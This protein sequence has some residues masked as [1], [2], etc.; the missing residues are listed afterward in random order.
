MFLKGLHPI[1]ADGWADRAFQASVG[2]IGA[3]CLETIKQEISDLPAKEPG[4]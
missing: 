3:Q 1:K 2:I 4:T